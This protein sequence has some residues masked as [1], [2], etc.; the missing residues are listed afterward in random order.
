MENTFPTAP[1]P[2]MPRQQFFKLVGIS[3]GT[4]LSLPSI[5]GCSGQANGEPTPDAAQKIDFMVQLNAKGNE[6]LQ[7][8]GGYVIVNNILVAHTEKDQFVAVSAGCSH[9]RTKLVYRPAEN[10]FYCPLDLSRFDVNGKV[11]AGPAVKPLTLY[12]VSSDMATGTVR[13]FN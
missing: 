12:S 4:L 3:I 13:V 8:K 6:G 7:T 2:T 11:V 1:Q 5:A 9:D 10:Q